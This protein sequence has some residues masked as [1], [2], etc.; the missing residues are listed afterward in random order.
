MFSESSHGLRISAFFILQM[1]YNQ[2]VLRV[3][4]KWSVEHVLN[5]RRE[6]KAVLRIKHVSKILDYLGA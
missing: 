1:F 5:S 3:R 6:R 2:E 4:M